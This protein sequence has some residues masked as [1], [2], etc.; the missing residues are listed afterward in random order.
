M[1]ITFQATLPYEF[2]AAFLIA[3]LMLTIYIPSQAKKGKVPY[4]RKLPAIEGIEKV[5]DRAAKLGKP[6]YFGITGAMRGDPVY[7]VTAAL[8]ILPHA[9]R[10]C[11]EK[12]ARLI[13]GYT[14]AEHYQLT[15]SIIEGSFNT[16]GK[17]FDTA[18]LRYIGA[19]GF[20]SAATE[21]NIVEHEDCR[22]A[23]AFGQVGA[24][25]MPLCEANKPN[26]CMCIEGTSHLTYLGAIALATDY[27]LLGE[28]LYAAGAMFSKD[29]S[30]LSTLRVQD[31]AKIFS[32]LII[33]VLR[34]AIYL[35][36]KL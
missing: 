17:K 22:A 19:D 10:I 35:G 13:V 6:V 31:L 33:P 16:A 11:A 27:S 24:N 12:G 1:S 15:R 32:V 29:V 30:T 5:I 2:G 25:A 14:Y 3:L 36:V 26:G 9:A 23:M 8:S 28:E 34:L 4:V 7:M 18:D 20:S 21:V